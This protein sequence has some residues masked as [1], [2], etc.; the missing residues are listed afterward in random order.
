MSGSIRILD[1]CA[2]NGGKTFA[3]SSAVFGRKIDSES[4][5]YGD[6]TAVANIVS[7]DVV[8]ERL[9]QIKGS[10]S[11]VGFDL[12]KATSIAEC[13]QDN[14]K[15]TLQTADLAELSDS[16]TLFDAVLV[17]APCSSSGVLRRRPSQ[18]WL[19]S[20][21]DTLQSLPN[22]QLEIIQKAAAF[23]KEGGVL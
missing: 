10:L 6:T 20:K 14:L 17:D 11:R 3:I 22:L 13:I 21:E 8:D 15:C 4:G 23:V 7:H 16:D 5:E 19:M 1:Y 18:R 12:D 9:R 2:G